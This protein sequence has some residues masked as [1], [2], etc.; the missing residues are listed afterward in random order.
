MA[1]SNWI[2]WTTAFAVLTTVQTIQAKPSKLSQFGTAKVFNLSQKT[3]FQSWSNLLLQ[4]KKSGSALD[5]TN[6]I[7][8]RA[9]SQ[10]ISDTTTIVS[11]IIQMMQPIR[12]SQTKDYTNLASYLLQFRDIIRLSEKFDIGTKRNILF[13]TQM[14]AEEVLYIGSQKYTNFPT[15]LSLVSSAEITLKSNTDLKEFR[16]QTGDVLLSKATGSGSSSLIALSMDNPHIFSHSTPVFV[17]SDGRALS[18]EAFIEDGVKLRHLDKDYAS[19]TKTRLYIY[20]LKPQYAAFLKNVEVTMTDFA[21]EMQNRTKNRADQIAA[22]PYDF[23]MSPGEIEKR[24][25]FCSSVSHRVFEDAGVP[26]KLNPYADNL[27]SSISGSRTH[28]LQILGIQNGK[29]PAPGDIEASPYYEVVGVRINIAK[30]SQERIESALFEVLLEEVLKEAKTLE[31]ISKKL[32]SLDEKPLNKKTLQD[33]IARGL[34]PQSMTEHL[35][36]LDKIPNNIKLSQLLL[37]GFMNEILTPKVRDTIEEKI[38]GQIVSQ[39]E[40]KNILR[41]NISIVKESLADVITKLGQI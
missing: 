13:L 34:I 3:D 2:K 35:G 10:H 32:Q 31:N 18:P 6:D 12:L 23:T 25:L 19:D 21:Q 11:S 30:L 24:G 41:A 15:E 37:F 16:V 5:I 20:R 26:A 36:F 33:L 27:W 8:L 28:L 40:L 29:V 22:F 39:N 7:P 17:D 38:K 14:M 1:Y 4:G 9:L